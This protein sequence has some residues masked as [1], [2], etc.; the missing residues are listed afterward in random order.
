MQLPNLTLLQASV[1]QQLPGAFCTMT[2]T[3]GGPAL[4]DPPRSRAVVDVTGDPR[5]RFI[6]HVSLELYRDDE[7]R[8]HGETGQ[9][10][11]L[12]RARSNL[13]IAMALSVSDATHDAFF[14]R[15]IG[16]VLSDTA[17]VTVA[18]LDQPVRSLTARLNYTVSTTLS[19]QWYTQAYVSRGTY[20]DIREVVSPRAERYEDR[21]QASRDTSLTSHPVGADF[22][23]FRSNAVLRWEYRPGSALFIVWT[24]GRDIASSDVAALRFGPDLRDLF[25]LRPSNAVAVKASYWISR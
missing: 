11:V 15:R 19:L 8:S 2:C 17:R 23:Q 5:R 12:W 18:R 22:R 14:Y 9:A 25:R 13:D 20:S 16:S 10:D 6:P 4:V 1:S 7:G 24:Q 21:F 3:R